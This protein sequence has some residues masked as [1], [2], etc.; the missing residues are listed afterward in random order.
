MRALPVTLALLALFLVAA[1]QDLTVVAGK[2]AG[3]TPSYF[4][5]EQEIELQEIN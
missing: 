1:Y 4:A 5:S 2:L 3:H